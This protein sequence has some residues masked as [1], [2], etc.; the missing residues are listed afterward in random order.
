MTKSL[1][2]IVVQLAA[3]IGLYYLFVDYLNMKWIF[4]VVLVVVAVLFVIFNVKNTINGE[5]ILEM[6][7]NSHKYLEF[8]ENKY[9]DG[10]ISKYNLTKAYGLIYKGDLLQAKEAFDKVDY[11]QIKEDEKLLEIYTRV[12]TK[13]SFYDGDE[14]DLKLILNELS[15]QEEDNQELKNYVKV[16]MLIQKHDYENAIS[17][18]IDHIP[19][20][21]NRVQI[22]ELEYYLAYSY[23]QFKQ[24]EDALAVCQFVMKKDYQ[25]IYTK[26]SRELFEKIN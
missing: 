21:V 4:I 23:Y 12:R 5:P 2:K 18:L 1:V 8:V 3:A 20:Q 14:F 6:S 19:A 22:I 13:I 26:K 15:E 7:C 16:Y 25:V 24:M 9:K 10:D 11:L 17:L